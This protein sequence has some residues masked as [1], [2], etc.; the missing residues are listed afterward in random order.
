MEEDRLWNLLFPRS[1][2]GYTHSWSLPLCSLGC[3]YFCC[4]MPSACV[5][6]AQERKKFGPL[7]WNIRY[8]F[9]DSDRECALLN[10]DLYCRDGTI[11]WD[12]LVY[13]TG[14]KHRRVR[15][16]L[17]ESKSYSVNVQAQGLCVCRVSKACCFASNQRPPPSV[18]SNTDAAFVP[19]Q[20]RS[21]TEGE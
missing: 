4:L 20:V 1:Y 21:R 12:A 19:P 18:N 15:L 9:N 14:R 6:G 7:G 10:L 8:E 5:S 13:I 2:P 11:P 3:F 17:G 16:L